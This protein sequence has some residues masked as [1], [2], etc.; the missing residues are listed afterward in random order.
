MHTR[1]FL[2][3]N[4]V[5]AL[6]ATGLVRGETAYEVTTLALLEGLQDRDMPDVMLWVIEQASASSECSADTRRRLEF[7]KGSALVSQSRTAVDIEARNGLL[8]QAEESIDAFLASSPVDDMAIDAF[9]KKGNLLVERG[10]I[11]LV[12]AERPGADAATLSKEAA[13]FFDR[14]IKT[15]RTAAPTPGK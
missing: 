12:L 2:A 3:V 7:L 14:A 6:L 4:L 11:C 9:T 15:L 5:A 13:A 1:L 8:D 10:R